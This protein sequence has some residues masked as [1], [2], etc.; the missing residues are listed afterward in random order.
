MGWLT[1]VISGVPPLL[2]YVI[3]AVAVCGETAL[4]AGVVVPTLSTLLLV[5]FLCRAGDLDLR[6]ALVVAV[7]AGVAGDHV[8]YWTGRRQGA[9]LRGSVLGRRIGEDRWTRAD[10]LIR[11]HGGRAA[12]AGRFVT[13]VRT[14][15]PPLCGS[16][17]MRYPAFA[18]WNLPGVA[19]WASLE[20]LAGYAAG[21]SYE[22]LSASF[23]HVTAA[24]G[25]LGVVGAALVVGGRWLGRNPDPVRMGW[26]LLA[27][28]ERARAAFRRYRRASEAVGRRF[29]PRRATAVRLAAGL[30]VLLVAGW[31]MT[32]LTTVAVRFSD[33]PS[34]DAKVV[35][36]F[37]GHRE[38]H[39][40]GRVIAIGSMAA[41]WLFVVGAFV[42]SVV[43]TLRRLGRQP[44]LLDAL[45]ALGPVI[46]LV[47]LDQIVSRTAD[48]AG[49][50]IFF[51]FDAV[52]TA[53]GVLAAWALTRDGGRLR[54]VAVWTVTVAVLLVVGVSRLATEWSWVSDTVTSVLL[55]AFWAVATI[56]VIR[57]RDSSREPA[58]A[59][60]VPESAGDLIQE[61]PPKSSVA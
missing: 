50:G 26:Q 44:T 61:P 53:I 45:A 18:L 23:G 30:A 11:S 5:G 51:S 60:P 34:V 4:I 19:G 15:V 38:Y 22:R 8:G 48:P 10:G 31:A 57:V 24:L 25:L 40:T 33:L 55:G 42:V 59:A 13:V 27:G 37:A 1:E 3:V 39:A 29:G 58:D 21:S 52:A 56:A 7:L 49:P 2:V 20:I 16:A 54:A 46:P 9:R 12:L 32:R 35:T 41:T 36:W 28:S 43:V 6:V 14:L 47:V 17:G